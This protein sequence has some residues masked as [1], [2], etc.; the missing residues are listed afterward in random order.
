INTIRWLENILTQRNSL[1]NIIS[2]DRHFL[3]T[4]STHIADMDYR[5]LRLFPGNND[6]YM[7]L[8][9]QSRQQMLSDN[10]KQKAN[11]SELQ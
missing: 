2:H 8:A 3:N 6:N 5:E 7:N 11:I 1:M 9:T 10:A 4:V